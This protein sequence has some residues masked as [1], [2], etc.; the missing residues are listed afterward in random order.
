MTY[1][2][3]VAYNASTSLRQFG[4]AAGRITCGEAQAM[5]SWSLVSLPLPPRLRADECSPHDLSVHSRRSCNRFGKG[6]P[7]LSRCR[8]S[9]SSPREACANWAQISRR[10]GVH[11]ELATLIC[12]VLTP[13]SV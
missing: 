9:R 4:H 11:Q 1:F 10:A 2:G 5:N 6:F 3:A 7:L 8:A 13:T 12:P